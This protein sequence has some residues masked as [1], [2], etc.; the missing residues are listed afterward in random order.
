MS[1]SYEIFE[2]CLEQGVYHFVT[3]DLSEI[4]EAVEM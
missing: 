3:T 4:T 2:V 1:L